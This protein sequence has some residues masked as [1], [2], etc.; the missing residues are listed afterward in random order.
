MPNGKPH[1]H[2]LTD[3]LVHSAPVYGEEADDLIREIAELCSQRELYEWWEREI[4]WSGND[5]SVV[6]KAR[7][8]LELLLRRAKDGGWEMEAK[9]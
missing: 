4:G 5:P 7:V 1:D 2:P 8:Q 3:I 9:R 6:H